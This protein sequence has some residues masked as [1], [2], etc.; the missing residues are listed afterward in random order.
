MKNPT[1]TICRGPLPF[2]CRLWH[3]WRVVREGW[4]R[5]YFECARCRGRRVVWASAEAM[6]ASE[7]QPGHAFEEA[8]DWVRGIWDD[9]EARA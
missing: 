8:L 6:Q 4:G 2:L 1:I 5:T 3:R 9:E 7:T